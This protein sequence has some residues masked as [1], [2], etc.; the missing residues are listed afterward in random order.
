MV[1]YV[2]SSTLFAAEHSGTYPAPPSPGCCIRPRCS[3]EYGYPS[4]PTEVWSTNRPTSLPL[5]GLNSLSF[6]SWAFLGP[7]DL[8]ALNPGSKV[9]TSCH[10]SSQLPSRWVGNKAWHSAD[11]NRE[12]AGNLVIQAS[13]RSSKHSLETGQ[14]TSMY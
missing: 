3:S 6:P 8:A 7:T 9:K 1:L 2:S 12:W 13:K 5:P 14:A 10:I 4:A 11:L